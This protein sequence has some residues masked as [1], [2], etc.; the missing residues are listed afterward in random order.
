M[1]HSQSRL[2][3]CHRYLP[4]MSP[5]WGVT[6]PSWPHDLGNT[7]ALRCA[8]GAAVGVLHQ[9]QCLAPSPQALSSP[10][11]EQPRSLPSSRGAPFSCA[12]KQ[13]EQLA[14]SEE[15]MNITSAYS[16]LRSPQGVLPRHR[17]PPLTTQSNAVFVP[18]SRFKQ[19]KNRA[20]CTPTSF[21]CKPLL[22]VRYILQRSVTLPLHS[23]GGVL[24]L[25]QEETRMERMSST[26][27][28]HFLE[29]SKTFA[30]EGSSYW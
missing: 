17:L 12:V 15:N 14:K 2:H 27:I 10:P 29:I 4:G 8:N 6:D 28:S 7:H 13:A 18:L 16:F 9:C 20:A 22:T 26:C 19:W 3:P 25:N 23:A 24:T 1:G 5:L 30:N 11:E 21:H